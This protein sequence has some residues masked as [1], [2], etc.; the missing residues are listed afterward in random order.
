TLGFLSQKELPAAYVAQF[1]KNP[2]AEHFH[3]GDRYDLLLGEGRVATVT[4]T[5]FVGY[6]SDDEDDDP[7]YIGALARVSDAT[8][9][10][11]TRG[12][13]ALRRHAAS[14]NKVEATAASAS[15]ADA[16][17]DA[18]ALTEQPVRFDVQTQIL[19]VLTERMHAVA[20]EEEQRRA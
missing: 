10:V 6:V 16:T 2:A 9:L 19:A 17:G 13:Y 1:Q 5:S 18:A 3:P 8:A 4:I 20:S 14:R 7:S 12:Y 15:L 11:G